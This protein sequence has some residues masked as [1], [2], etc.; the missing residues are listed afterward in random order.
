MKTKKL[1]TLGLLSTVLL[2][3]CNDL[4]ENSYRVEDK[5]IR[6]I[7]SLEKK[8]EIKDFQLDSFMIVYDQIGTVKVNIETAFV[9]GTIFFKGTD[10]GKINEKGYDVVYSSF[11]KN[12]PHGKT[13]DTAY[14]CSCTGLYTYNPKVSVPCVT[15]DFDTTKYPAKSVVGEVGQV[16]KYDL[17]Y[18]DYNSKKEKIAEGSFDLFVLKDTALVSIFVPYQFQE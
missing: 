5:N 4:P 13:S 15:M 12:L 9:P 6:T 2:T 16:D 1:L 14:C 18:I 3:G 17:T 10:F 8:E 11:L 7:V